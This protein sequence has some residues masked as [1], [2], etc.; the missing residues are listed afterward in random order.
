MLDTL[1]KEKKRRKRGKKLNLVG[2]KDTS[3][4][5]FH[6]SKVYTTLEYQVV[7]ETTKQAKKAEKKAKKVQV[8]ENK[9]KKKDKT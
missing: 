3:A 2:E 9:Q 5:L 6:S 4:Q 1:S 8:A 7:K